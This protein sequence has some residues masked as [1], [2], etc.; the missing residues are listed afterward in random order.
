MRFK[1]TIAKLVFSGASVFSAAVT[2]AVIGFM[3]VLSLPVLKR[4]GLF[5]VLTAPWSPDHGQFGILSMIAGTL[6]ISLLSLLISVP[7]SL[8]CSIFIELVRPDGPGRDHNV[9]VTGSL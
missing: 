4:A 5:D 7:L 9:S 2:L 1:D 3:V 8:G 6:C